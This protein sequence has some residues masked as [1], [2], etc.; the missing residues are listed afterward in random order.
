M[1]SAEELR[2]RTLDQWTHE[3]GVRLP[4]IEPGKPIQTPTSRASLARLRE[5]YLNEHVFARR[6]AQQG[7][8]VAHPM[9]GIAPPRSAGTLDRFQGDD[10]V[11]DDRHLN[12]SQARK[13]QVNRPHTTLR[14]ALLSAPRGLRHRSVSR[15]CRGDQGH[16]NCVFRRIV[17]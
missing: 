9:A 4:F 12:R 5:E 6:C 13:D 2:G 3:H 16:C 15:R 1:I 11:P 14:A 7:R 17:H 10:S 8:K